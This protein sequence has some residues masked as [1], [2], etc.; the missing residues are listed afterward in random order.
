MRRKSDKWGTLQ[1]ALV[2]RKQW[3][4]CGHVRMT[5]RTNPERSGPS[6]LGGP[7]LQSSSRQDAEA[8]RRTV[9]QHRTGDQA[10]PLDEEAG[11]S[12]ESWRGCR[13]GKPPDE[14]ERAGTL[15]PAHT[16]TPETD[17]AALAGTAPSPWRS[18]ALT[19]CRRGTQE[20][21]WPPTAG[22]QLPRFSSGSKAAN[23]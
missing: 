16:P 7:T 18:R 3:R 8:T 21:G 10:D 14:A 20:K 13:V 22:A 19:P 4:R 12:G 5:L 23:Q 15:P 2:P 6:V 9:T 11:S 1:A 17:L